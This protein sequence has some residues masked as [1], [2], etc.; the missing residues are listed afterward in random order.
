[1]PGVGRGTGIKQTDTVRRKVIQLDEFVILVLD[2]VSANHDDG[3]IHYFVDDHWSYFR[4]GV[5]QARAVAK[6]GNICW[7]VHPEGVMANRN[8]FTRRAANVDRKSTRLNSSH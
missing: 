4:I 3:I 6:L 2:Q 7:R 5:R 1:M 8:E